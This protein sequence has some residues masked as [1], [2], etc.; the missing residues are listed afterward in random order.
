MLPILRHYFS[1]RVRV[2][3]FS[4][5]LFFLSAIITGGVI[6]QRQHAIENRLLENLVWTGYQ[7]DREVRE[8]HLTL[9]DSQLG[10]MSSE[11]LLLRF[12][13]LFSRKTLFQQGEINL[14]VSK[15]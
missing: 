7:F 6:F 9:V 10:H 13:I 1:R 2:A 15:I 14:A 8:F 11:D 12:E 4:A 3:T 5:I